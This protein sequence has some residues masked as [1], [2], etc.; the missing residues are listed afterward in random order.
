MKLLCYEK[1]A[2]LAVSE[3]YFHLRGPIPGNV[4]GSNPIPIT[5]WLYIY[6]TDINLLKIIRGC[7]TE[8]KKILFYY[9]KIAFLAVSE[10]CFLLSGPIPR[11]VTGSNTVPITVWL[12]IYP[13]DINISRK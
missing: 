12:Y 11:N 3:T 13:I 5:V 10:T 7:D 8:K 6:L 4:T 2:I 1:I 9:E